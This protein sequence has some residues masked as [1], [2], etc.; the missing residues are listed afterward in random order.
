MR[1]VCALLLIGFSASAQI[2]NVNLG[3]HEGATPLSTA[4]SVSNKNPKSIVAYQSGK[5]IY[6]VDGGAAWNTSTTTLKDVGGTPRLIC[7]IKGNFYFF[8]SAD[9]GQAGKG[10]EGWLK[11]LFCQTSSDGGKTWSE[12]YSV[13]NNTSKNVYN[14]TPAAHPK[15][16]Q[17]WLSWTQSDQFGSNAEDCKS[18]ALISST[19][20]GKKWSK[21][22]QVNT[23]A[24]NCLDE[25]FT[26][27]GSTAVINPEGKVFA[28]WASQG[29]ILFDRSYDGELWLS[30][31]L[32]VTEQAGGWLQSVSGFGDLDGSPTLEI[33]NSTSKIH[34]TL[35]LT[36]ADLKSGVNDL[37][38]WL[39][40]SVNRGDNWTNAIK[41]N[42]DNSRR[43]QFLPRVAVD[44]SSGYV[45]VAYFDRRDHDDNKTD[46]Y[47]A[48]SID[49]GNVFRDKKMTEVPF[50]PGV[51][52]K[53][54]SLNNPLSLTVVKGVVALSWVGYEDGKAGTWLTISKHD[55][56]IRQ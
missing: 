18:N 56:L 26:I 6:S 21:P 11:Q 4:I 48:Y 29:L 22:I 16:E 40:R 37:D 53:T 7:D 54:K 32:A 15:K 46:V 35:F 36:F 45:Y 20:S 28:I 39:V 49:G 31:D 23:G 50:V 19:G 30:T 38:V 8:Y 42:T 52:D 43:N 13:T 25:D 10:S 3:A 9:P 27:H 41:I 24:G 17:I 34:G 14:A 51:P 2:K 44:Q 12:P 33:D 55:D 47:I 5:I 1:V